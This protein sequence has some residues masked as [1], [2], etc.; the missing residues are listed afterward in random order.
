MGVTRLLDGR[1]T[2]MNVG[3]ARPSLALELCLVGSRPRRQ[4]IPALNLSFLVEEV[5]T[6]F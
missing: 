2:S 5:E 1:G 3:A 4:R 6:V